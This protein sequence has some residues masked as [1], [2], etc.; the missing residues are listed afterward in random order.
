MVHLFGPHP[1]GGNFWGFGTMYLWDTDLRVAM[2]DDENI[3]RYIKT[4][5]IGMF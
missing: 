3:F 4:M 2:L 5:A 1:W